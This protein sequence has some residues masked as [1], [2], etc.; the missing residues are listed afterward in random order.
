MV[1]YNGLYSVTQNCHGTAICGSTLRG[2]L[3]TVLDDEH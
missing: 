1:L 2:C 3:A